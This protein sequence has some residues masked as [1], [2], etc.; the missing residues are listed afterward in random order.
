MPKRKLH[1][2]SRRLARDRSGLLIEMTPR[3]A[4]WKYVGF[5]VRQLA[6]GAAFAGRT[7]GQECCLVLLAGRCRV[8]V[9]GSAWTLGPRRKVF[10]SYP[11]AA[12]LPNGSEFRVEALERSE[13]ADCRA[14]SRRLDLHP[15]LVRPQDCGYEIRGGGNATRQIVDVLPPSFPADRLLICEVFTPSGN[16]SSSI[17]T[18][19]W[20]GASPFAAG[21]KSYELTLALSVPLSP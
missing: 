6:A 16:W 11:H 14:P 17:T 18:S 12:Y 3:R 20:I 5:S 15:Q 7:R 9:N 13:L 2:R 10:E 1:Y 8:I 19:S 21:M 4:G